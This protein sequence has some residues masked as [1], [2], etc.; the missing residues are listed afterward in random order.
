MSDQSAAAELAKACNVRGRALFHH[1]AE[2][3]VTVET[4]PVLRLTPLLQVAWADGDVRPREERLLRAYALE[5]GLS[6]AGLECFETMI[7]K[8]PPPGWFESAIELLAVELN[9]M[10]E[11]EAIGLRR[12]IESRAHAVA[13]A[14]GGFFRLI[15][16]ISEGEDVVLGQITDWLD[17][18]IL[19]KTMP[20]AP[21]APEPAP[22]PAEL[23]PQMVSLGPDTYIMGSPVLEWGRAH[24]ESPQTEVV[25]KP[26]EVAVLPVSQA[27]YEHVMGRNPSFSVGPQAAVTDLGWREA[28]EFCNHLSRCEDLR[29]AYYLEGEPRWIHAANGYRLLTEAEWEYAARGGTT[30]PWCVEEAALESVACFGR[31]PAEGGEALGL[32]AANAYGLQDM[33]GNVGE[34][35]WEAYGPYGTPP[36]A[37]GERV[38]RGGWYF[39]TAGRVRSASRAAYAPNFSGMHVGFRVGR[40]V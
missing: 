25:L 37:R 18:A 5:A 23:R 14:D 17:A 22:L 11:A 33:H 6:E 32:R 12:R 24:D 9:A 3:G 34:W 39:S 28:L 21:L 26:F 2:L 7:D 29:P 30:G 20:P 13:D 31:N 10:S 4:L 40:S 36:P 27:L 19:R 8:G 1:L 38:V 35:C 16:R 15:G